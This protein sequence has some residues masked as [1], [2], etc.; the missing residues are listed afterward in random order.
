MHVETI[1]F[2]NLDLELAGKETWSLGFDFREIKGMFRGPL[3]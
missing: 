2:K 1:K 3:D